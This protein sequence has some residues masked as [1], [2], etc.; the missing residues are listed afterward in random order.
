[1]PDDASDV[2]VAAMEETLV[3]ARLV[4]DRLLDAVDEVGA[5]AARALQ[6]NVLVHSLLLAVASLLIRD[7]ATGGELANSGTWVGVGAAGAAFVTG[8]WAYTRS[9]AKAGVAP[10]DID[11][12][13]REG[14][15][16]PAL[17]HRLIVSHR[18]WIASNATAN[19]RD[20]RLL[21]TSYVLLF[22]SVGA[23]SL[24]FA[25]AVVPS[26]LSAT[27]LHVALI[28]L[29]VGGP[30]LLLLPET[31]AWHRLVAVGVAV[32]DRFTS[33]RG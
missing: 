30:P 29:A 17:L 7:G 14:C 19:Q 22:V 12:V 6:L 31:R 18:R 1:M 21:F 23:Y 9:K 15:P 26:L 3:E 8:L 13:L 2:D 20:S 32:V 28:A 5:K 25:H 16:R 10:R 11:A 24:A 4:L 27:R 33:N